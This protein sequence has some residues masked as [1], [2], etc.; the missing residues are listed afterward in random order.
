MSYVLGYFVADGCIVVR[1]DRKN[2]PYMFNITS[3]DKEHLEKIRKAMSSEHAINIKM[4]GYSKKKSCYQLQISNQIITKD[5]IKLGVTPR[6]TYNL[7]PIKVPDK[8]FPDFVRGF[9]D[10][11]GTVYIYIING[12]PQIKAS[13]ISASRPFIVELNKKICKN[14]SIPP[15]AIHEEN[16]EGKLPK[17]SICFYINDCEK[18]AKF[19]YKNNPSLYLSRKSEIFQKWNSI[20]RR[21]YKKVNYPSKIGWQLNQKFFAN[22]KGG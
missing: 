10:G 9:F 14:L 18:L 21:K 17:Y 4:S 8:Y 7:K 6:K 22:N 12:T 13:F 16:R 2:S 19:M 5:L 3:A 20:N 1:K 15:K 11:D